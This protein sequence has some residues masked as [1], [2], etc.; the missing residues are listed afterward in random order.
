MKLVQ[1]IVRADPAGEAQQQAQKDLPLPPAGPLVH[2]EGA[3]VESPERGEDV[4]ERGIVV[5]LEPETG[6]VDEDEVTV[7]FSTG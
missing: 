7:A 4:A 6:G 1:N 3:D 2:A 5:Q